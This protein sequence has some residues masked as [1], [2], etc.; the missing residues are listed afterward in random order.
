MAGGNG[1]IGLGR[2]Q[3]AKPDHLRSRPRGPRPGQLKLAIEPIPTAR[4]YDPAMDGIEAACWEEL[5]QLIEPLN[6]FSRQDIFVFEIGARNLA[7]IRKCELALRREGLTFV[8]P[9]TQRPRP[10]IGIMA[11][12][13]K[14]L[15]YVLQKFGATPQ[16]R[17]KVVQ[18]PVPTGDPSDEFQN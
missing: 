1:T 13:E 18:R 6:I 12:S 5:R 4:E 16:D 9:T 7:Q 2:G 14:I 17:E 10:E 15:L 3:P 11:A 8:T